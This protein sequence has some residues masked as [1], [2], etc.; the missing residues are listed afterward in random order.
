MTQ[1]T[2]D[3]VL[4][5]SARQCDDIRV[6][7]HELTDQRLHDLNPSDQMTFVLLLVSEGHPTESILRIFGKDRHLA[8]MLI[9]S[10]MASG[11]VI[12][13]GN[14]AAI[15]FKGKSRLNSSKILQNLCRDEP[16]NDKMIKV[17]ASEFE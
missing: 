3:N 15:T 14:D 7:L 17:R 6:Q 11:Y 10:L 8:R 1:R 9:T 2:T 13:N 5:E 12:K 4:Y 16:S